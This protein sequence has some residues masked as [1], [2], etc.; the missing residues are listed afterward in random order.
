M[1][2]ELDLTP[3]TPESIRRL[4]YGDGYLVHYRDCQ[5]RERLALGIWKMENDFHYPAMTRRTPPLL[6]SVQGFFRAKDWFGETHEACSGTRLSEM[7][8]A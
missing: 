4:S 8:T 1:K 6:E 5:G 2:I 7:M 3:K